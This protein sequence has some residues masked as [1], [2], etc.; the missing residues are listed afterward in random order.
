MP[1]IGRYALVFLVVIVS[2]VVLAASIYVSNP[3]RPSTGTIRRADLTALTYYTEQFPPYNYQEND[4]LKGSSVDLLGE[5]TARLGARVTVDQVHLVSWTEGYQTTLTT[6]NS[7]IF[8]TFLL[9]ERAQSFKWV[10]PISTDSY[11]L[12]ARWNSGITINSSSELKEFRIGVITDDAAIQQLLNA[13]VPNSQLVYDTNASVLLEKLTSGDIDLWCYPE[14][15][16]RQISERTTGNYYFFKAVFKLQNVDL[17]FAFNKNTPDSTVAAFQKTLD[18]LSQ[19]KDAAA[20]STYDR[21]LGRYI[22]SIGLAQLNYTTEDWAPFNFL[23]DGQPSG[24]SVELLESIFRTAGVNRTAADVHVIPLTD[25]FAQAQKNSSTVVFSIVRNPQREPLYKWVGPFTKSSFVIYA[26]A[27]RNVTIASAEDLNKYVIGAVSSTIENNLLTTHGY[28]ASHIVNRPTPGE[29]AEMLK[30]GQID[31]WAT[32]DLTGRYE[33]EKNGVDPNEYEIV[34]VLSANDFY[35][36]FSRDIPDTL[37]NAFGHALEVVRNQK[38]AQGVSEYERIVYRSLGVSYAQQTFSDEAVVN[39]VN[40][41]VD[42]IERNAADTLRRINAKE[43]PYMDAQIPGLYVY[44]LDTNVTVV[45][46]PDNIMTVGVN[47]K[48][49]TDVTGKLYRDEIVSGA[50]QNGTG[51]VEYVY[52]NPAEPNLYY[53]TAYHQLVKGSD[54]NSYVVC[55]GNYEVYGKHA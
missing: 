2:A 23:E 12:F 18:T 17:Y 40:T 36:I 43:A 37:V 35:F 28:N 34:Y 44:V 10:G 9:P 4:T 6:N 1:R 27:S 45:A 22:P 8:S 54:G 24:L 3:G 7:V 13:G 29:L 5:I 30:D 51:W 25:A 49:T 55:C 33:M 50:L 52:T 46:N 38:D 20:V 41:T 48:G 15:V 14:I 32:G 11:A 19:E 39:L 16:G 42:A 31:L 47:F 53:K 26:A 21:I